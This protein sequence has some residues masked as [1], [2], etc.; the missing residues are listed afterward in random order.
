ML[1]VADGGDKN[2]QKFADSIIICERSLSAACQQPMNAKSK[3]VFHQ[4][5]NAKTV[6]H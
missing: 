1:T 6:F 2:A 5:M 3:T 4:P